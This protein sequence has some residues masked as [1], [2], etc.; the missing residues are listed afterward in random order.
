MTDSISNRRTPRDLVTESANRILSKLRCDDPIRKEVESIIET[1]D[2]RNILSSGNPKHLAA[3]I[4]YIACIFA[5][6]RMTLA[7]IGSAI[8]ASGSTVG[9]HYMLIARGLGFSE[10]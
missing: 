8:G 7:T 3:G 6:D 4:V 5:E 2:E 10:R 1:A 9:K